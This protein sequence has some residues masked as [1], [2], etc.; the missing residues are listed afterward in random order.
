MSPIC[1]PLKRQTAHVAFVFL[2]LLMPALAETLPVA[3]PSKARDT[4][5]RA[6]ISTVD[7]GHEALVPLVNGGFRLRHVRPLS[8]RSGAVVQAVMH[9]VRDRGSCSTT[10][11]C[12]DTIFQDA[13]EPP[14]IALPDSCGAAEICGN[15]AD[16]DCN[17]QVD[18][19]CSCQPGAQQSCFTGPPGRRNVAVCSDGIQTCIGNEFGTWGP[20]VGDAAPGAEVCDGLDNDCNGC[21]ER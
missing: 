9:G 10:D 7:G 2:A 19:G 6:S 20:C 17:G 5:L 18:D 14:C 3:E 8:L 15:G 1:V 12:P 21:V 11:T 13:F 4:E 16:D